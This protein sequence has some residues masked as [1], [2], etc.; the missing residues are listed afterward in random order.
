MG[1]EDEVVAVAFD[2]AAAYKLQLTELAAI[3]EARQAT[4]DSISSSANRALNVE[5][6]VEVW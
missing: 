6:D 5:Q 3:E 4:E 2:L 1:I